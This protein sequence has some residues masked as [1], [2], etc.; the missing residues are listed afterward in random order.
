VSDFLDKLKKRYAVRV[1][2]SHS[3]VRLKEDFRAE[4]KDFLRGYL[5]A[6]DSSL[7]KINSRA[8]SFFDSIEHESAGAQDSFSKRFEKEVSYEIKKWIATDEVLRAQFKKT[9]AAYGQKLKSTDL[10]EVLDEEF[11]Q[12]ENDFAEHVAKANAYGKAWGARMDRASI[13][14]IQEETRHTIKWFQNLTV[15]ELRKSFNQSL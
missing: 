1:D 5:A 6:L 4:V 15:T 12:F 9:Q 7:E 2:P 3:P 11:L 14:A 8:K 10:K 13:V